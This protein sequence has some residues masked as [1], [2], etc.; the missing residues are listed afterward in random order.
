MYWS[1]NRAAEFRNH[2]NT[3]HGPDQHLQAAIFDILK[4]TE[5]IALSS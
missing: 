5:R 1:T 4:C 3:L 2:D